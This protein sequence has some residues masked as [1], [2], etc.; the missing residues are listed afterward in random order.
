MAVAQI[1][2]ALDKDMHFIIKILD[3]TVSL[4]N[5]FAYSDH[6]HSFWSRTNSYPMSFSYQ[7]LFV[8]PRKI[9]SAL[10]ELDKIL[11]ENTYKANED[12]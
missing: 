8:D 2:E 12:Q 6:S 10:Q 1:L 5:A 9:D 7:H 11:E 3:D 4:T